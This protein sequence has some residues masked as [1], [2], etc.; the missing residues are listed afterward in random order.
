MVVAAAAVGVN[1]RHA[2]TVAP[3]HG[4]FRLVNTD[5][6]I[7]SRSR[8]P[9]GDVVIKERKDRNDV[10][11]LSFLRLCAPNVAA[12]RGLGYPLRARA[13]GARPRFRF[14]GRRSNNYG[15]T[16]RVPRLR[17]VSRRH[18]RHR[19]TFRVQRRCRHLFLR[20]TA[21]IDEY[22]ICLECDLSASRRGHLKR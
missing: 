18:R 2:Q 16:R 3:R 8:T 13:R 17:C 6:L 1:G 12:R 22:H 9:H 7:K 11:P 10:V 5:G 20:P 15:R 4:R 19:E 21:K 14:D